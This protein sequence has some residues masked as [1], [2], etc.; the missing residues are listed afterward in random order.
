[1]KIDLTYALLINMQLLETFKEVKE[2]NKK[3]PEEE[4]PLIE[5]QIYEQ[6]SFISNFVIHT[7]NNF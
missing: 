6:S 4:R 3:L 1:M 2:R 7:R 5:L